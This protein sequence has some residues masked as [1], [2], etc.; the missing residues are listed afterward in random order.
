MF[1]RNKIDKWRQIL[2]SDDA[3]LEE[4]ENA[5]I[6]VNTW[7][8]SHLLPLSVFEREL[9]QFVREIDPGFGMVAQRLKR[10]PTIIHKI[11]ERKTIDKLSVLQDVAG[12]RGIVSDVGLVREIVEKYQAKSQK[13]VRIKD[14]IANPRSSGYRGVHL[15][16]R[17]PK[18]LFWKFN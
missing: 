17:T 15:V 4:K 5:A 6:L 9:Q 14:Y 11:K 10:T 7:R 1:S 3:S 13:W 2:S 12:L 8:A 18:N 16:Y